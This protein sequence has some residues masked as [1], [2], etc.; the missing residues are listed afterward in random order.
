MFW[1]ILALLS[2]L[3]LAF[4]LLPALSDPETKRRRQAAA[5]LQHAFD[6]GLLSQDELNSKLAQLP[7]AAKGTARRPMIVV[8]LIALLLPFSAFALYFHLGEP[9]A[10]DSSGAARMSGSGATNDTAATLGAAEQGPA[11]QD[12][13]PQN[14]EQ[15][16]AGLAEKLKADP[17]NVDGWLLLGRAYKT[18]E[19]FEAARDALSNAVRLAPNDADALVEL[20][21]A[22]ALASI[23]RRIDGENLTMLQR[24]VAQQPDHQRGLWLLGVAAMQASRPADAVQHWSALRTLIAAD[25]QAV[26]ALDEQLNA[27]KQAAGS[28]DVVIES[29]PAV[30]E[31]AGA[32]ASRA[33]TT[34]GGA[35]VTVRVNLA[36]GLQ[37]R[38]GASDVLFVFARAAEGSK[39]P[40]AIERLV[41]AQLPLTVILDDSDSMMPAL[42]LSSMADVVVGARISKSGLATPQSGDLQALSGSIK[43]AD[44]PTLELTISDVLP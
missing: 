12:A 27:A 38:V 25:P 19:R 6:A 15:A 1:L 18:M 9:K 37:S 41:A 34:G 39:M 4:V 43:P 5:S 29:G 20:A 17:N 16:V 10:L 23:N 2:A 13:A 26:A 22:S 31:A 36:P 35:K 42:K 30:T 24:A 40:L 7:P 28:A 3:A 32:A 14:M 11:G 33:D 21:E 44:Q 8:S